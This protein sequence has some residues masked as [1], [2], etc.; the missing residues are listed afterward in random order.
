M[1]MLKYLLLSVVCTGISLLNAQDKIAA[2]SEDSVMV[3]TQEPVATAE[4]P[5]IAK[6]ETSVEPQPE[7]NGKEVAQGQDDDFAEWAKNL[8]MSDDEMDQEVERISDDGQ[9]A[10]EIAQEKAS[11]EVKTAPVKAELPKAV[12]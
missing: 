1:N 11:A 8:E 6:A 3:K 2:K 7:A 5:V 10:E 12:K 9:K 4:E